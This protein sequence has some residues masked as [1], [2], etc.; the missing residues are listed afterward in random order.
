[1]KHLIWLC[2]LLTLPNLSTAAVRHTIGIARDADDNTVRYIE[3]HQYRDNGEHEVRYFDSEE[4][5]LLEKLM[6]YEGLPQHP[7]IT[8]TDYLNNEQIA[9]SYD[10]EYATMVTSRQGTSERFSFEINPEIIVDAGF[11]AY[12][13]GHWELFDT[14]AEQ[15][16]IF[17][18]A[19]QNRL[20]SM[21]IQRIDIDE[22]GASFRVQ[23]AN[24]L[25]RML[26]PDIHLSYD[27]TRQLTRYEG[28][29]NLK[30]SSDRSRHVIIDFSHYQMDEGLY[31][32][33]PQWLPA[34]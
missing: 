28:F 3:H 19:G 8:Q 23:P 6:A 14:N 10:A 27:G 21:K 4:N 33:L 18:I 1:M 32:P 34:K 31:R 13:R 22:K 30:T 7:S 24:W 17:A 11:D 5:V 20:L 12:I 15:S 29:T 16:V 25:V 9:V 2:L 26:L